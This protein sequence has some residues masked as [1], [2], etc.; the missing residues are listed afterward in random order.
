[1]L[2]QPLAWFSHRY[3][4]GAGPFFSTCT[5]LCEEAYAVLV[6]P[7]KGL[8]LLFIGSLAAF[9]LIRIGLR[10]QWG[11]VFLLLL[12]THTASQISA[13]L[14]KMATH[15]LRPEVLFEKGYDGLGFWQAGPNNDS[16]PSAHVTLIFSLF[17]PFAVV[18][19]RYRSW[20][21]VIPGIIGIGRLI[22]DQHYVSDV[23]FSSWVVIAWAELFRG[24]GLACN[25]VYHKILPKK[26]AN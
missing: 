16:F 25:L 17:W 3:L 12:L 18:F 14:L 20:L 26:L 9:L 4:T 21:L 5:N 13:N 23:W 19:P 24:V 10:R 2:D 7:I 6:W 11:S 8:P 22:L 1:M 15:R